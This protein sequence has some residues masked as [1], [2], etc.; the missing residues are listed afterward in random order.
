M[1]GGSVGGMGMIKEDIPDPIITYPS[2]MYIPVSILCPHHHFLIS[3]KAQ[4]QLVIMSIPFAGDIRGSG[5]E[6]AR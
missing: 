5:V 4:L 3:V 1:G 2:T 6:E